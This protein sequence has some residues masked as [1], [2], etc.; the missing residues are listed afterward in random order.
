MPI[1]GAAVD[2]GTLDGPIGGPIP[3]RAR[4]EDSESE[5]CGSMPIGGVGQLPPIHRVEPQPTAMKAQ[6]HPG[7]NPQN[8]G[9]RR[10]RSWRNHDD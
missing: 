4:V 7:T 10:H 5:Y 1:T 9:N 2:D 6:Q 3:D 8:R